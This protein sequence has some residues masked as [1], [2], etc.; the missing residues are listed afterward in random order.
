MSELQPLLDKLPPGAAHFL[1]GLIVWIGV[2][3]FVMKPFNGW[4]QT[5]LTEAL[6]RAARDEKGAA[7]V[8]AVLDTRVYRVTAFLLDWTCSVKL[9]TH[10]D[11]HEH[12]KTD[13]SP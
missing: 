9:P 6:S 7:A 3:K 5:R 12:I 1:G 4:L 2:A 13:P 11:F 10:A 8:H